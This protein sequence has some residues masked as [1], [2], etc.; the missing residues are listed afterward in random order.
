[1]TAPDTHALL[2]VEVALLEELLAT[3]EL[4]LLD[5]LLEATLELDLLDEALE[6]TLEELLV[7]VGP[8]EHQELL[9]KLLDGNADWVQRKLPVLVA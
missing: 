2:P 7:A 8:T 6:A 3:L 9:S 4:D 1:M 5:E